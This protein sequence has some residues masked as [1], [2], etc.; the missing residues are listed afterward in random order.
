MVD[1]GHEEI[2][3]LDEVIH[4]SEAIIPDEAVHRWKIVIRD[5][6][7]PSAGWMDGCN[8]GFVPFVPFDLFGRF[9]V[10]EV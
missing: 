7:V 3:V 8:H 9:Y 5:E 6:V 10:S 1:F 4:R 2:I